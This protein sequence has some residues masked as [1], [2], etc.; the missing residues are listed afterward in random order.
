MCVLVYYIA[1]A[2]AVGEV[3]SC[4]RVMRHFPQMTS[5]DLLP[6]DLIIGIPVTPVLSW[7]SLRQ[8]CF[9]F[10][11]LS[12]FELKVR[13]RQ[14]V[15]R[16]DG[17]ARPL[18]RPIKEWKAG[19]SSQDDGYG[20]NTSTM[21]RRIN[22][23]SFMYGLTLDSAVSVVYACAHAQFQPRQTLWLRVVA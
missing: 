2:C 12:C 3:G 11:T 7:G 16:T 15:G 17:R 20:L 1:R 23:I 14:T 13:T 22:C 21:R 19:L 10:C 6:A 9:F 8:F 4:T 18:M 5:D